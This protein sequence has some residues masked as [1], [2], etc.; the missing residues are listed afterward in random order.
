MAHKSEKRYLTTFTVSGSGSFPIDMLRYDRCVPAS[1]QDAVE[2]QRTFNESPRSHK[3]IALIRFGAG[4]WDGT[5][6][7]E[8]GRWQSFGWVVQ[9]ERIY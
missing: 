2:I 3:P 8:Y 6:R 1:E 9:N 4:P 7:M 5:P